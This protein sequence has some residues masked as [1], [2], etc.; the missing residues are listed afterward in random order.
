MNYESRY[1]GYR[2]KILR[3]DLSKKKYRKEE[4]PKEYLIKYLGGRGLAAR[5]YYDEISPNMDP[6]DPY[7][8]LIFMTGPL[9]G[10]NIFSGCKLSLAT[11]SPLTNHYFCSNA[12]G[13][14][15]AELKFAGYDGII[16]EGKSDKPVYITIM[17]DDIE[18]KD[19]SHLWGLPI[20]KTIDIIKRDFDVNAK[21]IAIGPAGENL[22]KIS[23]I[24]ADNRSFGRGGIGAVMGSKNL[25]AIAI[26][27]TKPVHVFNEEKMRK[28]LAESVLDIKK[29]TAF[30]TLYGTLQYI[31]PLSKLG[32]IPFYNYQ[33]TSYR[34]GHNIEKIFAETIRRNY[35][36]KDKPCF[37]CPV[38]CTKYVT[39][40][41]TKTSAEL[42]YEI[43]WALGPNCGIDDVST[44]ITATYLCD[45]YGL[46]AIS[47]G[48]VIGFA[49]EA[50]EKG[51][52][53]RSLA[54]DLDLKFGNEKAL[55]ELIHLIAKRKGLGGILAEG[56]MR[57][58][59]KI[60]GGSNH[61]AM[62]VKGLEMTGYEPR[63]FFGIA[64]AYATSNRGACHNVGGWTI[65]DELLQPRIDRF[66]IQG[67]GHLVK[68]LQDTRAYID[69][70]GL[71]TIVRRGLG[72]TATPEKG[73]EL[74]YYVTGID[75]SKKLM[76]IGERVYNL[77][78]VILNR[79][80]IT[81][82]D[83]ILPQ[84]IFK[85]PLPDGMAKGRVLT[86][87]MF[88]FMLNEYYNVRGWDSNGIVPQEKMYELEIP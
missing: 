2:G 8:K 66:A 17:D 35:P 67:K 13:F 87:D 27:G 48:V 30:H 47:T 54:N 69:S 81:R 55:I 21:V 1:Y 82:N 18:F 73:E 88:N 60:G 12:G 36:V 14:A 76:L 37:R 10:V 39:D 16:I 74:L 40:V 68:E 22:V 49:M 78:R 31:E 84:R 46:D 38:M 77:E 32:A 23:N 19:A 64:L 33:R 80:G 5:Y 51:I 41:H 53:S 6:Y 15:G 11:K 59:E 43:V 72:F 61:F 28:L 75:F 86:Y 24:Q 70:L 58:S 50:Y 85:E 79:E 7:N 62:H 4:I 56:V 25:K 26:R 44:I 3:I 63:S 42:D 52:L 34:D 45:T 29:T 20:D 65:R 9:T 71:C 57:A 83:D